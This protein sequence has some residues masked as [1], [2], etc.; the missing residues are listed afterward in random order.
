MELLHTLEEIKQFD[1]LESLSIDLYK[2]ALK[3]GGNLELEAISKR[4]REAVEKELKKYDSY[5]GLKC[6]APPSMFSDSKERR[7]G[8]IA[9]GFYFNKFSKSVRCNFAY[10]GGSG[11]DTHAIRELELIK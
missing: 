2:L 9:G 11:F 3:Y 7:I 4:Y 8:T 5:I 6:T 1:D 10:T